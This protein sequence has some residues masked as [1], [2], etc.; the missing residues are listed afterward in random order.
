MTVDQR[1]AVLLQAQGDDAMKPDEI[2]RNPDTTEQADDVA[3]LYSWANLHGAKYRDFS[4]S[5]QEM[6]VQMRQRTMADR[7]RLAREEAQNPPQALLR[8]LAGKIPSNGGWRARQNRNAGRPH[9]RPC[10][11]PASRPATASVVLLIFANRHRPIR[12]TS[13]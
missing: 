1:A 9:C 3:T 5:R 13:S 7:A 2:P 6:R 12:A 4:A 8:R 11:R 10:P